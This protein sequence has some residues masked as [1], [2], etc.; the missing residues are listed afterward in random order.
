MIPETYE[1]FSGTLENEPLWL[2]SVPG[3]APASQRMNELAQMAPGPYFVF[4]VHTKE[5]LASIDTSV[6][7]NPPSAGPSE[8]DAKRMAQKA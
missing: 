8:I 7:A 3:F 2:E 4:C 6:S 1:I 5:M